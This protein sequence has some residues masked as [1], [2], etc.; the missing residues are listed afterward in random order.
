MF[1][2]VFNF[3]SLF[4][5]FNFLKYRMATCTEQNFAYVLRNTSYMVLPFGWLLMIDSQKSVFLFG[6]A[7]VLYFLFGHS[8]LFS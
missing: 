4:Q 7:Y 1:R 6:M 2:A 5:V 8:F 3:F